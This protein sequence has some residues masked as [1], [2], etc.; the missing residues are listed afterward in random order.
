MAPA[1]LRLPLSTPVLS[2]P[3]LAVAVPAAAVMA[4][5]VL[6]V[7]AAA[8]LGAVWLD[9]TWLG[10]CE[11]HVAIASLSASETAEASSSGVTG[12]EVGSTRPS[13]SEGGG[14]PS[15]RRT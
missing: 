10:C 7:S 14:G 4:V 12:P 13:Y 9:A 2:L 5:A 1:S 8:W 6:A 3:V 15:S 11:P